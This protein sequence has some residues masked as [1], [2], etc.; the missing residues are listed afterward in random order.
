MINIFSFPK[1]LEIRCKHQKLRDI[2][3]SSY[4]FLDLG[5][6]NSPNILSISGIVNVPIG[7]CSSL[8]LKLIVSVSTSFGP[9]TPMKLYDSNWAL[10]IF[11]SS[12]SPLLSI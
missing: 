12:L 5:A 7:S 8:F 2:F 4:L 9:I 11:L 10:R 6:V 3:S 1:D